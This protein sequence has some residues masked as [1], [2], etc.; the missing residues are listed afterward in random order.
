VTENRYDA[1]VIGAGIH[2]LSALYHLSGRRQLAR[3]GLVERFRLGHDRGSSHGRSRVTRTAYVDPGYVRW[4]HHVHAEAWPA[5][6]RDAGLR[7]VHPTRGCF[8]GPTGGKWET[9]ARAV[10]GVAD[11]EVIDVAEARHRYPLLRFDGADGALD[12]GTAGVVAA[13]DTLAALERLA[14]QRG[15]E[16]LE[17]TRVLGIEPGADGIAVDTDKGRLVTE[18]L[19]VTAGPWVTALL[20][21]L[22]PR[23]TVARQMVGYFVLAGDQ[24]QYQVGRFPVWGN[25]GTDTNGVFYGLPSFGHEGIKIARHVTAGVD[26]DPEEVVD[27]VD[28]AEVAA[29]RACI[30]REFVPPVERFVSAERCYYTNTETEDFIIDLHPVDERI[31]IGAGFSGHG[32]KFGPVTGRALTELV[33]DGKTSMPEFEALRGQMSAA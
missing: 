11:C 32:F 6:E 31:A 5:L 15:A 10:S 1:L 30:E 12:D 14:R 25:L 13:A 4:M 24:D 8:F 2:G 26:D 7:L 3:V 17:E 28:E 33:C 22:M 21:I 23:L 16:I 29:L 20:P 27:P 18:R 9:Y 19:V